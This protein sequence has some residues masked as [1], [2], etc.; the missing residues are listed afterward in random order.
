MIVRRIVSS[1]VLLV[2]AACSTDAADADRSSSTDATTAAAE[3]ALARRAADSAAWGEVFTG[4]IRAETRISSIHGVLTLEEPHT[5]AAHLTRVKVNGRT[6][7]VDSLSYVLSV[8]AYWEHPPLAGRRAGRGPGGATA[9]IAVGLG[10]TGCPA[11]FRVVEMV[12]RDSVAV[13]EAFG[14]CAEVPD[15][16][17]WD[18]DGALRMR[19]TPYVAEFVRREPGYRPRPP[20]TWIYRGGGRLEEA[21]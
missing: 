14:S 16:L 17:W 18:G 20:Q 12:S 9:L 11:E 7:L 1:A 13:T 2:A 3:S 8:Q 19:F 4:E 10:G 5:P 21:R 6:L 15:S